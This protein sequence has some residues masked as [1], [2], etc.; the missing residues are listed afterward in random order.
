MIFLKKKKNFKAMADNIRDEKRLNVEAQT[1]ESQNAE[2]SK[3]D[4]ENANSNKSANKPKNSAP[5]AT[6]PAKDAS[7]ADGNASQDSSNN[8]GGN[9][10]AHFGFHN[11]KNGRPI[12][13]YYRVRKFLNKLAIKFTIETDRPLIAQ[14]ICFFFTWLSGLVLAVLEYIDKPTE[15]KETVYSLSIKNIIEYRQEIALALF[16]LLLVCG[17]TNLV[18]TLVIKKM[19]PIDLH[20][21]KRLLNHLEH[22]TQQEIY[23]KQDDGFEDHKVT[24][25]KIRTGP[26]GLFGEWAG[27]VCRSGEFSQK[28]KTIF[29]LNRDRVFAECTGLIG[30]SFLCRT[31]IEMER[32]YPNE[33]DKY[34]DSCN[35]T[36]QEYEDITSKPDYLLVVNINR[37]PKNDKDT[38]ENVWGF[39]CID[40]NAT[41]NLS[42]AKKDKIKI[43][44]KESAEYIRY[45][46]K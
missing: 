37:I 13:P 28:S 42:D 31:D 22:I 41:R 5:K 23:N 18:L 6:F 25:F 7:P 40:W 10:S 14:R 24:L 46:I 45:L 35:L 21:T 12:H 33:S 20:A 16:L 32:L 36:K 9:T 30:M 3:V 1:A 11:G 4:S 39:L 17:I 8:S 29:S 26:L 43:V 19:S 38:T 2:H 44:A 27:V 15:G 34:M